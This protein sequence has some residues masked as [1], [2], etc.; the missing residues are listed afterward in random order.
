MACFQT[1]IF[2]ERCSRLLRFPDWRQIGKARKADGNASHQPLDFAQFAWIGRS[3][4]KGAH[5]LSDDVS[6]QTSLQGDELADASIR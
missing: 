3:D 2:L 1:G 6:H 4:Q 5:L